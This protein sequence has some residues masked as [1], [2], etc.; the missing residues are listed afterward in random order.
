[1]MEKSFTFL[2]HTIDKIQEIL[3]TL[4]SEP[5]ISMIKLSNLSEGMILRTMTILL[6]MYFLVLKLLKQEQTS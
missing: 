4:P 3:L 6:M 2:L 5:L 1:M